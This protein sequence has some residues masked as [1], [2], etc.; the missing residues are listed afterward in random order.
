MV[1]DWSKA[2]PGN[3]FDGKK[4]IADNP[5]GMVCNVVCN[6]CG[7]VLDNV[8]FFC[9]YPRPNDAG[10]CPNCGQINFTWA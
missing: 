9:R 3:P 4:V 8:I 1:I 7:L 10:P 6:T 2:K 5:E